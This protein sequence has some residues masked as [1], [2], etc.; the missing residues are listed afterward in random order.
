MVLVILSFIGAF[1]FNSCAAEIEEPQKNIEKMKLRIVIEETELTATIYDN[2]TTRDFI[3]MLP[4]TTTLDDYANNEKIF[5]PERKL[6]T[7]NAPDGYEPS[8]GDITYYAPWGDVAI[9]YKDFT[10]S[11]Q[12]IS[13]GKIDNNGIDQLKNIKE[14]QAIT[15][16]LIKE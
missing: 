4:I 5:Y 3:S 9:F 15:I 7:E 11:K 2:P 8:V 6:S 16:E 12:L 1:F 10:Y 14:N 13:I